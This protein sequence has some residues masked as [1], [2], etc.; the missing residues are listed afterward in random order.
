M[1]ALD[2]L[3]LLVVM[4]PL[5]AL[6][7]SSVALVLARALSAGRRSGAAAAAGIVAGDLLFIALALAGMT[8]LSQW[9]GSLFMLIKYAA[10][11]YLVYLGVSLLRAKPKLNVQAQPARSFS[12]LADFMAGLLLTL[13]DVKAIL[14]Y[15]SLF[16]T[17]VDLQSLGVVDVAMIAVITLLSVGGVKLAY[18]FCAQRIAARLQPGLAGVWPQRVG[19]SVLI[20]CGSVLALKA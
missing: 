17:V 1:N 4:V 15:A 5:A 9:L 12:L 20:G 14:F 11:A 8:A 3:S 10:A 16:P 2:A 19:G 7:S 6:P 13:G 18:V